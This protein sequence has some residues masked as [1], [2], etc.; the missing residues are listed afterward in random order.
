MTKSFEEVDDYLRD[1]L[2]RDR[3]RMSKRNKI[4]AIQA[5]QAIGHLRAKIKELCEENEVLKRQLRGVNV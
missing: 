2:L 3:I 4:M 1:A 5:G